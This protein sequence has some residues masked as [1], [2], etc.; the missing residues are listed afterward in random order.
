VKIITNLHSLSSATWDVCKEFSNLSIYTDALHKT[1][2]HLSLAPWDFFE[3]G[4]YWHN[5]I[6][7]PSVSASAA[8]G[9]YCSLRDVLRHEF[10][11]ALLDHHPQLVFSSEWKEVFGITQENPTPYEY[12]KEDF[13]TPY[14]HSGSTVEEDFCETLMIWVRHKG[15][16]ARF[17][18]TRPGVYRKLNFISTLPKRIKKLKI[19]LA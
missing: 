14:A 13:V 8:F 7:I 19:P 12:S 1:D 5:S 3:N 9:Q 11:H 10:G 15:D 4:H 2:V 16:F 18:K 17:R 6:V